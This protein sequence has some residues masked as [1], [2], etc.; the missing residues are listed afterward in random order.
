MSSHA[1]D[2]T[3]S[4]QKYPGLVFHS[5]CSKYCTIVYNPHD[6]LVRYEKCKWK[7]KFSFWVCFLL[8]YHWMLCITGVYNLIAIFSQDGW[9]RKGKSL[10]LLN[11]IVY[12]SNISLFIF[13]KGLGSKIT[14]RWKSVIFPRKEQAAVSLAKRCWYASED[15]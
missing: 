11:I 1:K 7:L 9:L 15:K 14:W 4:C 3:E 10:K 8:K 13:S 6:I 12:L 2:H 5:Q